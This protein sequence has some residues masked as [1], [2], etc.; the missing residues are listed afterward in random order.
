M[1]N[2]LSLRIQAYGE[3]HPVTAGA[4][5]SLAYILLNRGKADEALA[6]AATAKE[7][8]EKIYGLTHRETTFAEDSLGLALLAEGRT[9]EARQQFDSALKARLVLFP[10]NHMQTGKTWMFLAMSDFAAGNLDVA[11]EESRKSIDI[12]QRAH[13]PLG[14]PQSAEFDAVMLEILAAQHKWKEAEEF[15][16]LSLSKIRP[17]LVAGNPRLAAVESGL[18]MAFFQDGKFDR[19]EPLLREAHQIVQQT[20]GPNLEQTAQVGIR[21]AACLLGA[22]RQREA[23]G[24]VRRYKDIL[25]SSHNATYHQEREWLKTHQFNEVPARIL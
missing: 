2:A 25:L 14:H 4:Q 12:M 8:D 16:E 3:K 17:I 13:G 20:Y 10:P 5:S 24:L 1:R 15:G 6:L 11:A 23:Q 21:L 9:A 22:G 19:A 7:T 18:A